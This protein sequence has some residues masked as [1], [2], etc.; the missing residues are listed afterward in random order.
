MTVLAKVVSNF[1]EN[2]K[3]IS[4]SRESKQ[5]LQQTDQSEFEAVGRQSPLVEMW[6]PPLL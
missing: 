5:S 1:T 2:P 3:P 4:P 6:E